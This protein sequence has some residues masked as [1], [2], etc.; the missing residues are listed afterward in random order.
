MA[1]SGGTAF[2]FGGAAPATTTAGTGLSLGGSSSGF[3]FGSQG[4]RAGK[5]TAP[6]GGGGFNFGAPTSTQTQPAPASGFKFGASTTAGTAA[7]GT[8]APTGGGL[9]LGGQPSAGLNLSVGKTVGQ[10]APTLKLGGIGTPAASTTAAAT[11]ANL[12]G[13]SFGAKTT[14]SGL[15][16]GGTTNTLAG[17]TG[18]GLTLGG[19]TGLGTTG[20]GT[21]SLGTSGLG[22]LAVGAKKDLGT[23]IG[24]GGTN[25]A[26]TPSKGLGGVDPASLKTTTANTTNGTSSTSNSKAV[27]ETSLPKEISETV[28]GFKEY[29]KKQKAIRE[30]IARFSSKPMHKV[31][32]DMLA[33]RQL[34]SVVS[35]SLQR[36]TMAIYKLK[37]DSAY[38]LKNAD[39]AHRT[40][41]VPQA[42]QMDHT[43]P[44]EYFQRLIQ[45]FEEQMHCC[46]QEIEQ[47]ESHLMSLSRPASYTPQDLS[48]VMIKMNETFIALAAKLQTVHEAVKTQKEQYLNYRRVYH[49]ETQDIFETRRKQADKRGKIPVVP[50]GPGPFDNISNATA[51]AMAAAMQSAQKPAGLGFG[52]GTGA[53]TGTANTG[54]GTGGGLFGNQNTGL[55]T[56]GLATGGIR[57]LGTQTTGGFATSFG[58]AAKTGF[59]NTGSTF[60]TGFGST[61]GFGKPTGTGF[62][63][64]TGF[65]KPTGTTF[66]STGTSFGTSGLNLGT[67]LQSSN[68]PTNLSLGGSLSAGPTSTGFTGFGSSAGKKRGF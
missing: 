1:I 25:V 8:A 45:N 11:T 28:N 58:T 60:G 47:I 26:S 35:N 38:E 40:H 67:G 39:M 30:E 62:G 4:P 64:T 49:G 29:V 34:L 20:I 63:S 23:G 37:T 68:K 65:G 9:K 5:I 50:S 36:N 41:D 6:G 7:L 52:F 31:K 48:T 54:F 16:L 15:S 24:L 27:K 46:H 59:G 53:P 22:G 51:I 44:A 55:G 13:F 56:G 17:S 42:L 21:S 33:L 43:A 66:G 18:A 14:T 2:N 32:E 57:P 19:T 61:T 10:V 12:G 3:A